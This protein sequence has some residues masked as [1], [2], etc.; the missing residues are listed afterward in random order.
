MHPGFYQLEHTDER[1][2]G[3]SLGE[4]F[5]HR[6]NCSLLENWGAVNTENHMPNNKFS[7]LRSKRDSLDKVVFRNTSYRGGNNVI[8]I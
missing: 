1:K 8:R 7:E 3:T 6:I 4:V 5:K 2:E